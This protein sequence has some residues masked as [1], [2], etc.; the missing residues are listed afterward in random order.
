MWELQNIII[1]IIIMWIVENNLKYFNNYPT[2]IWV[3]VLLKEYQMLENN[4]PS[5]HWVISKENL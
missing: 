1:I 4:K 2:F 3:D 5:F